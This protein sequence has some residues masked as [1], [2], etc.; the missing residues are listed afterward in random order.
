MGWIQ[1]GCCINSKWNEN[2]ISEGAVVVKDNK[3]NNI[4][5]WDIFVLGNKIIL[6]L[7]LYTLFSL[8]YH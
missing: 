2:D 5:I 8:N 4:N 1:F 3:F 7:P 6:Q